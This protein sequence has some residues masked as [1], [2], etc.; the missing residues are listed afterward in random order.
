[1]TID[2]YKTWLCEHPELIAAAKRELRGK[3]LCCW[4]PLDQACHAQT[5]L[6]IANE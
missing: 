1:M 2:T 6:E 3:N 4:C 5:L